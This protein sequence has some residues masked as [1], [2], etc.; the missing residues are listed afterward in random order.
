LNIADE[1]QGLGGLCRTMFTPVTP[2]IVLLFF[3]SERKLKPLEVKISKR[4]SG[5]SCVSS[6]DMIFKQ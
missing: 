1:V 6:S 3:F 4:G 2:E 5:S